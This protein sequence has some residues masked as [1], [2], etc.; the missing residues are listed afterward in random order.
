MQLLLFLHITVPFKSVHL[1]MIKVDQMCLHMC[2]ALLPVL[3]LRI[4]Q[5]LVQIYLKF[6]PTFSGTAFLFLLPLP[7]TFNF[8]LTKAEDYYSWV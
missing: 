7:L 1:L 6:W 8:S 2:G 3:H 4:A 5:M